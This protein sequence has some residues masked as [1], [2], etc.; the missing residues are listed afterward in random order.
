MQL[1]N[2]TGKF[3]LLSTNIHTNDNQ[4]GIENKLPGFLSECIDTATCPD[5]QNIFVVHAEL[6][7]K[8]IP[9]LILQ[10]LLAYGPRVIGSKGFLVGVAAPNEDYYK[11]PVILIN[12]A[13]TPTLGASH[14]NFAHMVSHFSALLPEFFLG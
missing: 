3:L 9:S 6:S 14:A 8:E 5:S 12:N 1:I 4:E 13:G 11:I 2:S 10:S 7:S